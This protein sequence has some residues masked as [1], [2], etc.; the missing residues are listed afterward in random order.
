MN[1]KNN[2]FSKSIYGI[3]SLILGIIYLFLAN[4]TIINMIFSFLI[5][6]SII[7]GIISLKNDSI[8][9]FGILG[10]VISFIGGVMI[11]SFYFFGP[12]TYKTAVIDNKKYSYNDLK[13]L[14]EK[15][16]QS[17]TLKII[18]V[19]GTVKKIEYPIYGEEIKLNK[20]YLEEG[21]ILEVPDS[22]YDINKL[23]V[24]DDIYIESKIKSK[25][26][27][28]IYLSSYILEKDNI[29][30]NTIINKLSKK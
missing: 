1:N 23:S 17:M 20:I 28:N 5:I 4:I 12:S 13:S 6:L 3:V 16:F 15:D 9:V 8:K 27:S 11:I 22:C 14:N 25:I 18:K 2:F 30:C 7:F 21:F 29:N 24:G 19:S 26:M 10:I